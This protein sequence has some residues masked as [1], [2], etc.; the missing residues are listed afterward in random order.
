MS[1]S[2]WPSCL[3]HTRL[4][5]L[6][7]S[8][9]VCSNSCPL[10]WWCHP[11]IQTSVALFS[12]CLQCSPA[13]GSFPKSRFFASGGQNIGASALA[14]VLPMNIQGWFPLGWT[15]LITVD[16]GLVDH[17]GH[18]HKPHI[19][20]GWINTRKRGKAEQLNESR[21]EAGLS[22]WLWWLPAVTWEAWVLKLV[23]NFPCTWKTL[24]KGVS[25]Y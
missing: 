18:V 24:R 12:F 11:T 15:G 5:C 4:P 3:Q 20:A 1:D 21:R 13:S 19:S 25:A 8:P 14:S 9:R 16:T 7:P 22:C 6:S 2:L 23:T 10:S 17:S